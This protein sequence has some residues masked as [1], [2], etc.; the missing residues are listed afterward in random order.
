MRNR[1]IT[2]GLDDAG[3][4]SAPRG[5]RIVNGTVLTDE[6]LAQRDNLLALIDELGYDA[7]CEREAYTW[8]NRF[9]GIR[10]MSS[11][12]TSR[13][14]CACSRRSTARSTPNACAP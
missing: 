10:Y 2:F 13:A 3:R 8:F 9:A 6:Q 1:C 14:A 5:S 11:T 12:A 4:A 7:L